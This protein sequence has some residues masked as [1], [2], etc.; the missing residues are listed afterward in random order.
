MLSSLR[1]HARGVLLA[2]VAI[3]ALR[4]LFWVV[5]TESPSPMDE[6]QHVGYVDTLATH[7][8][9]PVIGGDPVPDGMA[10]LAKDS[11]T[12][13]MR[14]RPVTDD[15][16]EPG[17]GPVGAN[18]EGGQTP[19]GYAPFVSLWWL[20]RSADPAIAL[21]ATRLLAAVLALLPIPLLVMAG[22]RLFP[23]RDDIG[24]L[25]A[26]VYVAFPATA[27]S[28]PIAAGEAVL[29]AASI[30]ALI[31]VSTVWDREAD[32]RSALWTGLAAAGL[33]LVKPASLGAVLVLLA[34]AFGLAVTRATGW[35]PLA[36]WTAVGA[37]ATVA[38]LVPWGVWNWLA[39]GALSGAEANDA[40]I[41]GAQ[42]DVP[43]GWEAIRLHTRTALEG[44]FGIQRADAAWDPYELTVLAVL[45]ATSV[46]GA[47]VAWRRGRRRDAVTVPLLALLLPG[48][49]V[50]M[51]AIIFVVFDARSSVVG[52]HLLVAVPAVAL[53]IAA[54]AVLALG[55]RWA[56][57]VLAVVAAVVLLP[58]E[59]ELTERFVDRF[60]LDGAAQDAGLAVQRDRATR[61]GEVGEV[62]ATADCPVR[63]V[64]VVLD[65]AE[66]FPV[67]TSAGTRLEPTVMT[68]V[69]R[70]TWARY[71][72]DAGDGRVDL[73][74]LG[75]TGE[76][77]PVTA[78]GDAAVRLWC[79]VDDPTDTTFAAMH[80]PGRP[81][82]MSHDALEA[83]T[84]SLR[85]LLPALLLLVA[86]AT[87]LRPGRGQ[88]D[89]RSRRN[90]PV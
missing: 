2:I 55:R 35:R 13:A 59:A 9:P 67:R 44:I 85:W 52:R 4:L 77:V 37:A 76:A 61:L 64:D 84:W 29:P 75:D 68:S 71:A 78:S 58:R 80:D 45:L 41:G 81:V 86:A 66:P 36:R 39:Y 31:A 74:V 38:P 33:L 73:D 53:A 79:D 20:V 22:R 43:F 8:R 49:F 72:V 51:L 56:V 14:S 83:V 48:A 88:P 15:P 46:A 10:A 57:V 82:S 11:P 1:P 3:A 63:Y 89:S 16:T 40:L 90:L 7:G 12:F 50:G 47:I 54:G 5:L 24:L 6:I 65:T 21:F 42:F 18:Y 87:A 60:Y 32:T 25:A 27:T 62:E 28:T 34:V 23:G 19:L 26:A 30:V 69:L 70:P 17:W